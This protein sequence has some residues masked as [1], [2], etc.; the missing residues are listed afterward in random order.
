MKKCKVCGKMMR[1]NRSMRYE[2]TKYPSG[3]NILTQDPITYE[4]FDCPHCG[5][6]NTVNVREVVKTN[7]TISAPK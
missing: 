4:C 7:E 6:Q 1:L 3:L 5:C 2:I